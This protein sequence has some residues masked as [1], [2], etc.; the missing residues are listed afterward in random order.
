MRRLFLLSFLLCLVG[1]GRAQTRSYA[2]EVTDTTG[3]AVVG[4]VV[5]F[6]D[7]VRVASD[8]DGQLQVMLAVGLHRYVITAMGYERTTGE[9]ELRNVPQMFQLYMQEA[10]ATLEAVV[11]SAGRY[12]QRIG[13]VTQSLSVLPA[14]L[15]RNKNI[16]ALNDALDQVPGVVVVDNDPQIRAGSGFSYGAG[17][18][19]MVLVDD[20][21]VL[22]GDIGRPSWSFLPIESMEQVEVIKGASS[23]LYGS[24]ALS[25]VINLRTAYP[26]STPRTRASVFA[27]VYDAP[28]HAP[29]KWWGPSAPI[30]TG[31]NFVH[32]QQYGRFDLVVGGGAFSDAGYIGPAR[33][34]PAVVAAAPD[35]LGPAGFEDRIRMNIATRWRNGR[36][37]GLSY[38]V[39]ANVMKSRSANVFIWDDLE[40]GLFRAEPGTVTISRGTQYYVDPFVNYLS[41]KGTKHVLRGRLYTQEFNNDN[42]QSNSNRMLFG[43]Y[44][45]QQKLPFADGM[46]VTAGVSVQ[47]TTSTAEL[48]R[49]GNDGSGHNTARNT[50]GYLQVD[51]RLFD[52][53]SLNAGA[54][55]ESFVVNGSEEGTPVFRGGAVYRVLEATYVRAAYGQGFRYPTIGERYIRTVLGRLNI[56]PSP[57]L[58]PER[59]SNLEA[60]V[61]QG[62]RIGRFQG[63]A[64]VAVFQQVYEDY[65]EFTFG[66]WA[67]ATLT[68]LYGLG[69]RSVNTGGA[70]ITGAEVEVAASGLV[71]PVKVDV[72]LGWTRTLPVSTTPDEV[73]AS[74]RSNGTTANYSYAN[75][76]YD[77]TDHILKFRVQELFRSDVQLK[78]KR[79]SGGCSVRYNSHVRNIDRAFVDLDEGWLPVLPTGA[80]QW[81]RDHTTGDWIVDARLGFDLLPQLRATLIVNNLSNEVYALRPMSIEA[82]R[83]WQVQ[84]LLDI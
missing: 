15:V 48:Y 20:L 82:P 5:V 17:S 77:T 71:G 75:T 21:P 78:W 64:D 9:V 40:Q 53:L 3:A 72:L 35:T 14:S 65:V 30:F 29:A 44:Q 33:I 46:T 10:R 26:R 16:V 59:S 70:R 47:G 61:K 68:N 13:E 24:A 39:N 22:S 62:F 23:V 4:A 19:V 67:P 73:Y 43:E 63:Y 56:Y 57:D 38:G 49:G 74:Y 8:L 69:F 79:L 42:A 11:V 28:G 25:G 84:L 1:A 80:G 6:D 76:S 51:Q 55:Y 27:G 2:F 31:A 81:M 50:A 37:K 36:V 18:R 32:A 83:S 54:R 58:R 52:R 60:G 41:H 45:V 12:E 66:V 7:S 34:A